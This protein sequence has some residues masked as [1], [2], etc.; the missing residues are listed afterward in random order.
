MFSVAKMCC[1][2]DVL[3]S[4]LHRPIAVFSLY[5]YV[6]HI[7]LSIVLS[8]WCIKITAI[9]LTELVERVIATRCRCER[10][11]VT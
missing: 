10:N 5:A 6:S 8:L 4:S 3:Q 2:I 9:L 7:C 11:I 1:V